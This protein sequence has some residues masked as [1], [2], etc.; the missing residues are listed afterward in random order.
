[1]LLEVLRAYLEQEQPPTGWLR[2]LADE[3]LAPALRL[4]HEQPGRTWTLVDLAAAARMSRTSFANRFRDVAGI[5]PLAY[6]SRWRTVLAQRA[7]QDADLRIGELA[8][9]LGYGSESAFSTAFKRET[10][11]A[12]LHY[13]H[14]HERDDP[15]VRHRPADGRSRV[16]AAGN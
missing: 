7:L 5:T 9:R 15:G 13:R 6:L 12:P 1:M 10:G 3:S 4:I 14:R 11:E 16:S 8:A 2:L